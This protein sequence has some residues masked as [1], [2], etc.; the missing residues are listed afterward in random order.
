MG[1]PLISEV[2]L[3][4]AF[5]G[6]AACELPTSKASKEEHATA[7]PKSEKLAPRRLEGV[8]PAAPL[9]D[10]MKLLMRYRTA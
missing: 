4:S 3:Q 8:M 2:L 6:A 10:V 9:F 5:H 7:F 1:F